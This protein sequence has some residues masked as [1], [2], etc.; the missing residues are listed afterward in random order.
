MQTASIKSIRA[1][2][3][4]PWSRETDRENCCGIFS[5]EAGVVFIG[6]LMIIATGFF[7]LLGIYNQHFLFFAP[8]I[9]V[10]GAYCIVFVVHKVVPDRDDVPS[11]QMLLFLMAFI[12]LACL[13]YG[14]IFANEIFN[15]VPTEMCK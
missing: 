2:I 9:A 10:M 8:L 11:R 6:I 13:G 12:T 1:S 14:V 5:L 4:N 7:I 15:N 3:E